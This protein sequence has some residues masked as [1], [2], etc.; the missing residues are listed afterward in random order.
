MRSSP[1]AIMASLDLYFKGLSFS[2]ISSHLL[3]FYNV[4]VTAVTVY[5]WV[6]KYVTLI[7]GYTKRLNPKVSGKWHADETKIKV[8]GRY[9]YLWDVMDSKTRFL[10]SKH[11]SFG[12]GSK[13][14]AKLLTEALRKAGKEPRMLI[15]DGLGSYCSAIDE[16]RQQGL[17]K[18][19]NHLSGRSLRDASN[20]RIERMHG[21][22]KERTKTLRGLNNIRSGRVFTD[23]LTT[24][25]NYVRPHTALNGKTPAES[26]GLGVTG[27]NRWRFLIEA[28][29]KRKKH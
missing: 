9:A 6:Q 2:K 12:R 23:G 1:R 4:Q 8:G 27:S 20:N 22:L 5:N 24:Y 21:T 18:S 17:M 10:V 15:T 7:K 25:Y 14:A 13:E 16:K 29:S 3:D 11:L 26:A 19:T 28:A